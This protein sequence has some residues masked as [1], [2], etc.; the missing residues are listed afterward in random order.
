MKR[1]FIYIIFILCLIQI[2]DICAKNPM[3]FSTPAP[4]VN[5]AMP[6]VPA[7]PDRSDSPQMP[8]MKP[9]PTIKPFPYY[10]ICA[11]GKTNR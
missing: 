8:T 4:P 6:S 11:Y 1:I 10:E 7:I 9:F 3:G 2:K 5:P